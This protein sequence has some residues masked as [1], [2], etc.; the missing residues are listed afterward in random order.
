MKKL[1]PISLLIVGA[2]LAGFNSSNAQFLDLNVINPKLTV[3]GSY[4]SPSGDL[5]NHDQRMESISL[6]FPIKSKFRLGVNWKDLLTA[7]SIINAIKKI[8]PKA[9]QI[10]GSVGLS[11]G[12]FSNNWT[13]NPGFRDI[14]G[15]KIGLTGF[16]VWYKNKRPGSFIWNVNVGFIEDIETMELFTP[17]ISGIFGV[18]GLIKLKAI[19]FA[20]VYVNHY[21]NFFATPILVLNGR[22]SKK[23]KY[24]IIAP[25][26]VK[27]IYKHSK[28]WKQDFVFGIDANQ[29][30]SQVNFGES[31]ILS[32]Y[33][34]QLTYL[35]GS[36]QSRFRLGKKVHWYLEGGYYFQGRYRIINSETNQSEN[37]PLKGGWFAKSKITFAIAKSLINSGPLNL[38]F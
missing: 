22:I 21:D 5:I 8:E 1:N 30:Q 3:E 26:E 14:A 4:Y 36:T 13:A 10:M 15:G 19:W 31:N 9:Y 32:G 37:T 29:F 12:S 28:S 35:K 34:N 2:A 7:G 11:H 24:G 38:D 25:K 16:H 18:G 33:T 27:L 6:Q 20:G 17:N 23:W